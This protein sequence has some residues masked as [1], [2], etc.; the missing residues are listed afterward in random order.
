MYD[1]YDKSLHLRKMSEYAK[2]HF[3]D[4]DVHMHA[5]A[6]RSRIMLQKVY[7]AQKGLGRSRANERKQMEER[8]VEGTVV[9]QADFRQSLNTMKRNMDV[10][11]SFYESIKI[12]RAW[13]RR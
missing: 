4:R 10:L 3:S 5:E 8:V 6:E 9:L 2:T 7:N 1:S 13:N 11:L 12:H